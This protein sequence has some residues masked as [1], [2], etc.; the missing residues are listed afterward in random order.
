MGCNVGSMFG[1]DVGWGGVVVMGGMGVG[2]SVMGWSG[3]V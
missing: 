2:W 3:V 1:W